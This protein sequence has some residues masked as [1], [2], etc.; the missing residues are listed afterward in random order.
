MF[1][2]KKARSHPVMAV[3]VNSLTI[4]NLRKQIAHPRIRM[5]VEA[6]IQVENILYFF[7]IKQVKLEKQ[8]ITGFYW[9]EQLNIW[10]LREYPFPDILYI[11]GGF[12]KEFTTT[13]VK[14]FKILQKRRGKVINYPRFN[15]W[16]LYQI[17]GNNPIMKEYLPETRT[18]QQPDDIVKML[19]ENNAVYLK[20]HLGRKGRHVMQVEVIAEGLY[21]Y[22]FFND[23]RLTSKMVVGFQPL[24]SIIKD[25]FQKKS[26]LVQAPIRLIK[27]QERPVDMRADLQ[28]NGNGDVEVVG[29]AVR[30]G[31]PGSP[32]TTH[33]DA[34]RFDE[35]F[36][37][38]MGYAKKNVK[39]L[40]LAAN[41]FLLDVFEYIEKNYGEYVE[42]GI[43]FAIDQDEK[44]WF[45]EANS[46]STKVSLG[47]A[48]GEQV[49]TRAYQNIMEYARYLFRQTHGGKK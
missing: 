33:G 36:M 45:I 5:L 19:R 30:L 13:F 43:D 35:F 3:L 8:R 17:M 16:S 25:F 41:Q 37:D 21:R 18:V 27:Y 11:R 28:R 12:G 15:K 1:A 47:K 40:Q 6:N 29:I 2:Y 49:L 4:R 39:K 10:L 24:L 38:K 42:M 20:S 9:D 48:Y 44:I 23:G 34:L 14:L 31:K 26:F 32:I 7:S 22:N 46:Q